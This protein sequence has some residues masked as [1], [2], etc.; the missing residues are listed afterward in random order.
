M[1]GRAQSDD[2]NEVEVKVITTEDLDSSKNDDPFFEQ[3]D[4]NTHN[5]AK[6]DITKARRNKKKVAGSKKLDEKVYVY[7]IAGCAI[8]PHNLSH[9][10]KLYEKGSYNFAAIRAKVANIVGL[11]YSFQE[12]RLMKNKIEDLDSEESV[13]KL[14]KKIRRAKGDIQDYLDSCNEEDDI[15]EV[16]TKAQT[17]YEI[18]GNGYIEVGRNGYGNIGYIG[19]IPASTVRV[20]Y[21]KDGFVQMVDSRMQFFRNFGDLKTPD[22]FGKDKRPNEIIQLKKYNPNNSYYGLPDILPGLSAVAGNEFASRYNLDF[23]EHRAAPRYIVVAKG[24]NLSEGAQAKL[25]EFLQSGLKGKNHR[26]VFI[27]LPPDRDGIKSELRLEPVENG[28][29]DSSF[30]NYKMDNRDEILMVHRTPITKVGSP[31]GVNV[32]LAKD[33]DKTFKEQVC[34]PEQ[35]ILEK[36]INRIMKEL[37]DIV[38]IKFNELTL[39]DEDAQSK[40]DER[41]L[42]MQVITPNEVRSNKDM[43]AIDG[44]DKVVDLKAEQRAQALQ[45]RTRDQERANN[46]V[47]EEGNARNSKG[48]GREQE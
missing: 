31:S 38:E 29:Q 48:E 11:G 1:G 15:L 10:G 34:R 6:R 24:V 26:S 16:F 30:H 33:Q 35:K 40:I 42:R 7:D 43:P 4:S 13:A 18:Y 47:D 20:R 45:S 46:S 39:T 8:P 3:V 21:D 25:L 32:A 37:T 9:L 44:G 22:P 2:L 27:P 28:V 41:Y 5:I 23:F 19:H 36:K 17:D 12:T 14:R